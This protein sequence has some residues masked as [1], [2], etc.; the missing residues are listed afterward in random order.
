MALWSIPDA[1]YDYACLAEGVP[2]ME[3]LCTLSNISEPQPMDKVRDLA[4]S[5]QYSVSAKP[6]IHTHTRT[7]TSWFGWCNAY[8]RCHAI[9]VSSFEEVT[10]L[11]LKIVFLPS[12][13]IVA[14][15]CISP[16]KSVYSFCSFLGLSHMQAGLWQMQK[17][18][19]YDVALGSRLW[20]SYPF[21]ARNTYQLANCSYSCL[22]I[23]RYHGVQWS[24]VQRMCVFHW[25]KISPSWQW[26]QEHTW[27]CLT[28]D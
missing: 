28:P 10:W 4:Y 6:H 3:P 23:R 15:A 18:S 21:L 14:A 11:L 9:T 27:P 12:P 25:M 26:A 17:C 16:V 2:S 24:M 19:H 7:R 22:C 1:A 20:L 13:L 8:I 5:H